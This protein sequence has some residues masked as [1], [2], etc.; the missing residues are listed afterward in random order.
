MLSPHALYS[1]GRFGS[2]SRKLVHRS[3]ESRPELRANIADV[4]CC[5]GAMWHSQCNSVDALVNPFGV[6]GKSNEECRMTEAGDDCHGVLEDGLH[7]T[8]A[9]NVGGR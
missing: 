8:V 5:F 2:I 1:L 3:G 7:K 4:F 9:P 6:R